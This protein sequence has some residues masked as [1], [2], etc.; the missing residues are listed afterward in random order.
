MRGRVLAA[1]AA[2]VAVVAIVLVVGTAL[3]WW[4]GTPTGGGAPTTPLAAQ[5]ALDPNPAFYGD[6]VTA[7]VHVQYDPKVVSAA[8][9]RVDTSFAPYV[10][11]EPPAVS[12]TRTG[13]TAS[14]VYRYTIQCL[15]DGCLPLGKPARLRFPAAV[16]RAG[17]GAQTAKA[18]APWRPLYVT[19]RLSAA[20]VTAGQHFHRPSTLLP[21]EYA[22]S[23]GLTAGLLTL[24]AAILAVAAFVLVG[25][26]VRRVLARRRARAAGRLGRREIALAY[27][28]DA[29]A[30]TDA[31]DRRKALGLLAETL[32]DEGEPALAASAEDVAWAEEE[33][34]AERTLAVVDDVERSSA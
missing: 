20:D 19:S 10:E 16:V 29:A 9:I 8:S 23:P 30:R 6:P 18:T 11:T 27:A 3:G 13:G 25:L 7:S 1:V 14:A 28:R 2:A 15:T 24:A 17:T 12:S 32:A 31:A 33:P 34:S 26:E 4:N 5:T 22:V 21:P